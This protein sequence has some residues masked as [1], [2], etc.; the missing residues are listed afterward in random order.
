[1]ATCPNCNG[2]IPPGADDCPRC[3]TVAVADASA[4]T[5]NALPER[6]AHFAI[7][8]EL[9]AGGMGA[10]YLARDERMNRD[11]AL[12]LMS[13]SQGSEKSERRFEQ[14]AWIAGRLDHPNIVKVH[15][16]GTWDGYPYFSMEVVEG[17]SLAEVIANMR[18]TG[19]DDAWDLTFGSSPYIHW[20]IRMVIEA[21]R[22]LD[23]AHRQGVVHRDVKPMNLLLSQ[24]LGTVKI[25]DFGLAIDVEVTRMTTAGAVLGTI[26]FMAPEQIRGEGER[27]DARTDVYALGVTLFELLTLELP[28]TGRTQQL[29]MSQ[30]LTS[31][32]RRARSLNHRVS[33]DL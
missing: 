16:R 31:A 7:R 19:R 22:G 6:I 13:R 18:R 3:R 11:V 12:K 5:R 26:S 25:A 15:E 4:A 2:T 23:F 27:I 17:G 30:V 9:G 10:V 1:M 14:E 8:R 24:K 33:R 21:A 32:A 29:Y 20:A 28:Y